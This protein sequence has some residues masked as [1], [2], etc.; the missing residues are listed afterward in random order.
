MRIDDH[1]AFPPRIPQSTTIPWSSR[2]RRVVGIAAM[3]WRLLMRSTLYRTSLLVCW[4]LAMLLVHGIDAVTLK[5]YPIVRL[6]G[7]PS[8]FCA[9]AIAVQIA[10]FAPPMVAFLAACSSSRERSPGIAETLLST[11]PSTEEFVLAKFAAVIAASM[12]LLA[13]IPLAGCLWLRFGEG[14]PVR[15]VPFALIALHWWMPIGYVASLAFTA[16]M[17]LPGSAGGAVVFFYWVAVVIS[18]RFVS[19]LF[20]PLFGYVAPGYL[21]IGIGTVCAA[22]SLYR[23]DR[24]GSSRPIPRVAVIV[25]MGLFLAGGVVLARAMSSF[26][27]P[28][29][30]RDPFLAFGDHHPCMP[31]HRPEPCPLTDS[32]EE[33]VI[34]TPSRTRPTVLVIL[35]TIPPPVLALPILRALVYG[36]AHSGVPPVYLAGIFVT[37]DPSDARSW[38]RNID[39]SL[40]VAAVYG[41]FDGDLHG[42]PAML[43]IDRTLF[44]GGGP[45]PGVVAAFDSRGHF[46]GKR[47]LFEIAAPPS[48][49]AVLTGA[50]PDFTRLT[51]GAVTV[52]EQ[53]SAS[54]FF[55]ALWEYDH[56][57][58]LQP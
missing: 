31:G 22:A 28:P 30:H 49:V 10:L 24:R 19:S 6:V 32:F 11:P 13:G 46:L 52:D 55:S 40:P 2:V 45:I 4:A 44:M 17:A 15:I 58:R 43:G 50:N 39:S 37:R 14:E 48:L 51:P 5:A 3:E 25:S 26:N 18:T 41:R 47:P 29:F 27:T 36:N 38:G 34:P 16:G 12:I 8:D 23:R 1:G 56:Q 53:A 57:H 9:G 33:R 20:M 21:L 35:P 7:D 42:L 54:R